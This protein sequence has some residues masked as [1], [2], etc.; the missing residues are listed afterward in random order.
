MV[1]GCDHS[2]QAR[3]GKG[4]SRKYCR[5]HVEHYRRHGSYSKPS[6]SAGELRG[7]RSAALQWLLTNAETAEVCEAVEQVRVLYNRAGAVQEAFRLAGRLPEERARATW[8]W[9]RERGVDPMVLLAAWLAVTLRH[10]EDP[11]PERKINYRWVQAAK[12]LHRMAGG[13][14][15]RWERE[16]PDGTVAVTVLEKYPASRGR[17]LWHLGEA[18]ADAARPIEA[19]A[20]AEITREG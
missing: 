18:L 15:K 14:R 4:L 10:R 11:Q 3:A 8:A 1:L 13:T 9:L 12:L 17:V 19:R 20:K 2:T 5:R 7:W 6:Y 16:R